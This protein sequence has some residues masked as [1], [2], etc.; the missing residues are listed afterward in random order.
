MTIEPWTTYPSYGVSIT[1]HEIE[2]DETK[3]YCPE[4]IFFLEPHSEESTKDNVVCIATDIYTDN[5]GE[6]I[7]ATVDG[8]AQMFDEIADNV[9]VIDK[10]GNLVRELYIDDFMEEG[11]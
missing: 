9:L 2:E 5:I 11:E 10:D 8:I 4:L 7:R 3:F 6:A 1:L